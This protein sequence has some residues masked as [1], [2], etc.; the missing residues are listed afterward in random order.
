[1]VLLAQVS[2]M[3]FQMIE[4]IKEYPFLILLSIDCML[5]LLIMMSSPSKE[6]EAIA[7]KAIALEKQAQEIQDQI[8]HLRACMKESRTLTDNLYNL[9]SARKFRDDMRK[10]YINKARNHEVIRTH[11][12]AQQSYKNAKNDF[13]NFILTLC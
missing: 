3:D 5:M 9:H 10:L 4:F 12:A 13:T 8:I 11:E 1:M 7:E 2:T 6:L